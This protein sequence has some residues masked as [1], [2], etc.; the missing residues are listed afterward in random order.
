MAAEQPGAQA[1]AAALPV[2]DAQRVPVSDCHLPTVRPLQ[3]RAVAA[4]R[5]DAV[6]PAGRPWARKAPVP[7]QKTV[8]LRLAE[9][10][11]EVARV[12]VVPALVAAPA[13]VPPERV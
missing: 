3:T 12:A 5:S 8:A 9:E 10:S 6:R 13:A 11:V 1:V 4:E 7:R 2:P